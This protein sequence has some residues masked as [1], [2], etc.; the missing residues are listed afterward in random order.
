MNEIKASTGVKG[1]KLF[2]PARFN[3]LIPPIEDGAML[4]LG[5]PRVHDRIDRFVGA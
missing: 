3:K 5:V 4:S 2:H 1:K